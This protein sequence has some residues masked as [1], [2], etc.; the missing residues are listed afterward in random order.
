MLAKGGEKGKSKS[1]RIISLEERRGILSSK[2][3]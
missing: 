1:N 3:K 2:L